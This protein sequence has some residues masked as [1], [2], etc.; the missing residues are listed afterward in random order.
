[1]HRGATPIDIEPLADDRCRLTMDTDTFRWP[2]HIIANLGPACRVQSPPEFRDH[3]IAVA[4][5]IR[6]AASPS[7]G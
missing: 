3:L 1:M 4:N 2:T 6:A 5:R 7:S